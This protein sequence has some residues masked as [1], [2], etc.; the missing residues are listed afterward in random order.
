MKSAKKVKKFGNVAQKKVKRS[1]SASRKKFY[2]TSSIAYVNAQPHIGY[3]LEL[4][5]TD[6]IARWHRLKENV[7]FLTGTDEHGIK[8]QKAAEAEGTEVNKFVDKMAEKFKNLTKILNISNDYFIRTTDRKV[9]WPTAEKIW[10]VLVDKG[11]IYKKKYSGKY[12]SG[13]ESFKTERELVDG[14]CPVHEKEPEV[15]VEENYFFRLSKY[16]GKILKLIESD[17]L[18]ILPLSRKNEIVSFLREGLEN[19]SFSRQRNS[20]RWGIPVPGEEEQIIYVWCD[21]LTNYLSGIGFTSDEKKFKQYWPA[22]AHVIGKDILRFH[23]AIWPA[24]LLSAG[25]ELP[26]S[27]LV[28]GFIISGGQKMSK[29][30]GNVIYPVE[31]V[32]KYG[33][34]AVRYFLLREIPSD[35]DGDYSESALV[36]RIN[37]DLADHLGNLVNRVLVM[38]EKYF[39][40]VPEIV[41]DSDI[42][43]LAQPLVE[44]VD[45]EID[46]FKLHNAVAEVWKFI[47][48]ANKYINDKKPWGIKDKKELAKIIYTL[49][50]SVRFIS[51]LI[52]PFLPETSEKILEQL[53]LDSSHINFNNLKFGL[54]KPKQKIKRGK[55]LFKKIE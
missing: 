11:D 50:E 1:I 26:K 3:A 27:I 49:L 54:L 52:H 29:S 33:A 6:A 28:H 43:N 38:V 21:A 16:S 53:G 37:S 24:L 44:K 19:I 51:L 4:I 35:E 42:A 2:I 5:Q 25:L 12:C 7:F 46:N 20:L 31:Q 9:H 41:I 40:E 34:D 14:K 18:R 39:G 17:K 10:K 22:D 36:Q 13:C 8:I 15:V 23:A 32:G 45:I 47:A 55:I 30:L 48:V